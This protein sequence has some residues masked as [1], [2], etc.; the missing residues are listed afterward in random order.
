MNYLILR[1]KTLLNDR[2][3]II[4]YA[5]S[6]IVILAVLFGLNLHAQERSSLP[7]G[8]I[9]ED[10]SEMAVKI[11]DRIRGNS[12]VYVYEGSFDELFELMT[13][14]YV[15]SIFV[16]KSGYAE[17]VQKGYT[18]NLVDVYAASDNKISTVLQDVFAGAMMDDICLNKAYITYSE[19]VG[20][21]TDGTLSLD[22]YSQYVARE[23]LDD[24]YKFS[25]QMSFEDGIS[26]P[27][28]I[29]DITN[30]MMYRQMIALM[31]AMLIMIV[32]FSSF[33]VSMHDK[34]IGLTKR[35][36]VSQT[37]GAVIFAYEIV[38]MLLFVLPMLVLVSFLF[39]ADSA[40]KLFAVNIVFALFV[41][42]VFSLLV[43]IASSAF[44]YRF[45]G[46]AIVLVLSIFG[47][48]SIFEGLMGID[49]FRATPVAWY[50]ERI[51]G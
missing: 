2:T 35:L 11:V 17:K 43:R 9:C 23:G 12:A 38:A 42:I 8:L 18:S 39:G 47:F 26:T 16:I 29:T 44:L 45:I 5:L 40:L 22:E 14:G 32:I 31:L 21:D 6:V 34:E 25:F 41:C 27:K 49:I 15:N 33:S 50:V 30:S 3:S 1:L 24:S 36:A 13:D 48:I 20:S 28:N 46:T 51:V 4:C 7:I 19:A 10:D 37:I